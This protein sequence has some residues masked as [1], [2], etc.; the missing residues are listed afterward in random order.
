MAK[1]KGTLIT[2]PIRPN[3]PDDKMASAYASEIK[4]GLH[5]KDNL[6][7]RNSIIKARRE[8]GMLC[9]VKSYN[10]KGDSRT[11]QLIPNKDS[12]IMNN[13]NWITFDKSIDNIPVYIIS[14]AQITNGDKQY[15]GITL[16]TTPTDFN[17]VQVFINGQ[18]QLIGNNTLNS[19]CYFSNDGGVSSILLSKLQDGSSLY[20]NGNI[21]GF[22]LDEQDIIQV[23]YI[24]ND[25][26]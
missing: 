16:T 8:W 12:N 20:F 18:S 24:K 11:Y 22:N 13:N 15:T 1:N 3:S 6:E 26:D 5:F 23:I 19:S 17:S 25:V 4:G 9:F 2:S 14:P 7:S 10:S 21:A